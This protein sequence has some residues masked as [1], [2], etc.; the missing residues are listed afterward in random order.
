VPNEHRECGEECFVGQLLVGR[1][2][3]NSKIDHHGQRRAF[4]RLR[5]E[6]IGRLYVAMN[7]SLL[8]RVLNGLA[9]VNEKIQSILSGKCILIAVFRDFDSTDEFHYEIR[10]ARSGRPGV[11]HFGDVRMIHEGQRLSFRFKTRND[12]LGVHARLDDL[13]RHPPAERLF[14]FR[15]EDDPAAALADLLEQFVTPD[16]IAGFLTSGGSLVSI[17]RGGV[18][19]FFQKI[20]HLVM[21]AQ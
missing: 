19:G 10:P 9:N 8:V 4:Q 17:Q 16:V 21:R 6:D 3:G 2:F 11:E 20:A 18:R 5:H 7:D 13:E 1:C 14:L 12:T 15:H